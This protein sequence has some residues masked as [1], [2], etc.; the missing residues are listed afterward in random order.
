MNFGSRIYNALKGF[1]VVVTLVASV[2]VFA[3]VA[4]GDLQYIVGTIMLIVAI[5]AGFDVW[6]M[7]ELRKQV[8]RLTVEN[9]RYTENNNQF[10]LSNDKLKKQVNKL[11]SSQE[12]LEK[13]NKKLSINVK[14]QEEHLN[15]LLKIQKQSKQLIASLMNMGSDYADLNNELGKN[16][17]KIT[18]V[19][20]AMEIILNKLAVQ[21]F[22]EI[23]ENDDGIITQD[24]LIK[25]AS[26]K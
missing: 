25:W 15:K 14:K 8:D 7:A 10:I 20:D 17:N 23:D 26:Q 6:G 24:E 5:F 21:K 13:E 9:N 16:V 19:S 12:I 22:D 1:I 18:N 3:G 4:T 11:S 2:L